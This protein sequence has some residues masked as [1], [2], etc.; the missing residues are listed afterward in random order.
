MRYRIS[1][2]ILL[3]SSQLPVA[4][5][6]LNWVGCGISKKAFMT[7]LAAAYEKDTNNTIVLN[8]GGATKGIRDVASL[9]ADMGGT[10]R[11]KIPG[12][13][14]E[15][16]SKLIPLAWDALVVI[17]HPDNPINDISID[18]L[19]GIYTGGITNWNELGGPDQAIQLYA[20]KGKVSGVGYALRDLVFNDAEQ[21]FSATK[22]FPSSGPLEKAVESNPWAMAVTGISS[23]KKRNVKVTEL[24]GH[25][26][27]YDNIKNGDYL[28][29]R[30][31]YIAINPASKN[32]H[33]IN[34]FI[35]YAHSKKGQAVIK[36][37]GSVPYMQALNL[38]SNRSR[39]SRGKI[40]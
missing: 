10:C 31:L 6:T 27:S 17:V 40:L 12:H 32:F 3:L 13:N 23:A 14:D 2:A 34:R 15:F 37:A 38:R 1:T 39:Q 8:G 21:E 25:S 5:E 22:I 16:R 4:A 30:P 28:L 9:S 20:R 24:E 11:N 26:A 18:Q 7:E 35:Q 36:Q 33:A 29:Y 19:R